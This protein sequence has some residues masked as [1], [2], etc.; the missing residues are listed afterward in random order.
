MEWRPVVGYEDI[1]QVSEFGD[2][3]RIKPDRHD[4]KA[5]GKPM[6]VT[7]E[8]WGYAAIELA[9]PENPPKYWKVHRLVAFAFLGECPDGMQV[10]HRDGNKLNNHYSNLE[11]V[12]PKENVKH[13]FDMGLRQSS[14]GENHGRA[15]LTD[16]I[17]RNLRIRYAS[18]EGVQQ[19]AQEYSVDWS[20]MKD[21]V[22][23]VTWKHVE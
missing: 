17:V 4:T 11:Y 3:K 9:H 8:K 1:Y 21:A 22:T 10:N 16:D 12:T 13:A 15:K 7:I 2:V 5:K 6:K 14:K 23:R 18:G 19:L 20:T